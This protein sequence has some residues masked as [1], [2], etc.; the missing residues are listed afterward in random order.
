MTATREAVERV[1]REHLPREV[2]ETWIGLLRPAARLKR[3]DS[4]EP[5]VGQ[6]GGLPNLHESAAWPT[7]TDHGPLTFVAS[8]NCETLASKGLDIALP[9]DG[10]LAFF[11]FDGQYDDA[12]SLVIFEKPE[13]L[14]GSRVLYI[15]ADATTIPCACPRGIEAY[16]RV[17]LSAE[18]VATYPNFEHPALNEVFRLPGQDLRSFL[19]NPV[20]DNAFMEALGEL[21]LGPVHQVGGYARPIQGPV[22]YEVALATLGGKIARKD[23]TFEQE[24]RAWKLLV[25]IDSDDDAKMM[26]GD[27]GMLYWMM[28]GRDLATR[29]FDAASFTWQCS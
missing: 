3:A 7:W 16:P 2:A 4:G 12:Q 29:A 1:A 18:T 28:R 10:A 5:V 15:P 6:L 13:S 19:D 26:W 9:R 8:V 22:E 17:A 11:Y 24:A 23:P 25:Q 21:E 27:V 20:N 14:E